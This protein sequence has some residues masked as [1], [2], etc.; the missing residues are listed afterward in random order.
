MS[1]RDWN[2]DE[3]FDNECWNW[4]RNDYNGYTYAQN[5]AWEKYKKNYKDA[6][7]RDRL[8]TKLSLT[9]YEI[10]NLP[11]TYERYYD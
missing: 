1:I 2:E 11:E 7:D 3:I 5:R 8:E 10:V 4:P 9:L 6:L